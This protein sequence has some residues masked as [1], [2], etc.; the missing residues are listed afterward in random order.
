MRDRALSEDAQQSA[1]HNIDD[2]PARGSAR[3]HQYLVEQ[4]D[5]LHAIRSPEILQSVSS[6]LQSA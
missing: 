4:V 1:C 6:A 5:G 2:G 3:Y